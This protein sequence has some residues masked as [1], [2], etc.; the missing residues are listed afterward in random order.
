M[1]ATLNTV[2]GKSIPGV[3]MIKK[4]FVFEKKEP[5]GIGRLKNVFP[6]G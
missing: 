6:F 2:K 4:V 5:T 1:L 3:D